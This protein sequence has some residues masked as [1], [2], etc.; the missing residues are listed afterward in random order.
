MTVTSQSLSYLDPIGRCESL[1]A[2]W[3][4]LPRLVIAE[5]N[6]VWSDAHREKYRDRQKAFHD[7]GKPGLPPPKYLGWEHE[8][9]ENVL[10]RLCLPICP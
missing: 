1:E 3:P 4:E 8:I 10:C 2:I 5:F 6:R 7:F 9:F